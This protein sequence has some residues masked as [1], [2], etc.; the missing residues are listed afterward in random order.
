MNDRPAETG[1]LTGQ[2]TPP[3]IDD[4][5][6]YGDPDTFSALPEF[7]QADD[8]GWTRLKPHTPAFSTVSARYGKRFPNSLPPAQA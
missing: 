1:A 6:G 3:A 2:D 4:G 5:G 8:N 7:I